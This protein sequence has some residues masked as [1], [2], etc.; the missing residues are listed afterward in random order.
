[1]V[2]LD[3]IDGPRLGRIAQRIDDLS[4][5]GINV[6]V[7]AVVKLEEI[8]EDD[9]YICVLRHLPQEHPDRPDPARVVIGQVR[10]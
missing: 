4:I 3:E 7:K 10:V 9:D 8:T 6:V 1:M 2:P 5:E